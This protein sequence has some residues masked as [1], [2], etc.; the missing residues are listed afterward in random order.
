MKNEAIEDYL[1]TIYEIQCESDKVATT[2]LANRM[3]IT[4][5]SATGM[6]KK[7]A[8]MN[9]VT[10][11]PYQGIKLTGQGEKIALEV[12]RQ[13]RLIELYLVEA[14]GFS[15]DEV[16]AEAEKLEHVISKKLLDRIDALL[17]HPTIDPHGSP[18]PTREGKI[19]ESS[20]NCLADLKPG[21]SAVFAEIHDRDPLLL[22]YL[23]EMGLYPKVKIYVVSIA[24]F[25]GPITIRVKKT[26]HAIGHELA[27]LIL[28][29]DI[30]ED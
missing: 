17:G 11:E 26:E 7:L 5:A 12:L 15:W 3:K 13:H 6:I 20:Q 27:K 2:V 22:R 29:T 21:Q 25:K 8:K 9:L 24:P 1:K 16:H 4:P 19:S 28:I 14:M 23:G 10:Y 18:I 30:N